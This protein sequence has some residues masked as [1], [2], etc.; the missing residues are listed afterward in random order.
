MCLCSGLFRS[1]ATRVFASREVEPV[2]REAERR[3]NVEKRNRSGNT[4][5]D[6]KERREKDVSGNL[7]VMEHR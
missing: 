1:M 6:E 3:G 2:A 5:I 4:A 7:T